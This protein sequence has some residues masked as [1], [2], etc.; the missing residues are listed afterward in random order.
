VSSTHRS[1]WKRRE[2]EAASLFGS[3][4]QRCSGSS[5]REDCSRSDS[6]HDRL[7][8]ETKLK[9][10]NATVTLFDE[11]RT[12]AKLEGKTPLLL[13]AKKNRPGFLVVVDSADLQ[14]MVAEYAAANASDSLE[15]EIRTAYLRQRGELPEEDLS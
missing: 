5:G 9:A 11:T 2:R 4:R 7:F 13:L 15:G 1:T 12:L 14:V 3:K 6:T 10:S 8:I